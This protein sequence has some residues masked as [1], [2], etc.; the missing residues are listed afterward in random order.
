MSELLNLL[1][2]IVDETASRDQKFNSVFGTQQMSSRYIDAQ[3]NFRY[4]LASDD[5]ETPTS[6]TGTTGVTEGVGFAESNNTTGTT[7]IENRNPVR[8][9]PGSETGFI[10]TAAIP[11]TDP[12]ATCRIGGFDGNDGAFLGHDGDEY[13]LGQ[14]RD[15]V[16]TTI[17]KSKW[18]GN[19]TGLDLSGLNVYRIYFGYLGS[20]PVT[21]QVLTDD[22]GWITL[23]RFTFQGT[24]DVNFINPTLPLRMEVETTADVQARV[25]SGS[26]V[27][28]SLAEPTKDPQS[29]PFTRRNIRDAPAAD[30]DEHVIT[31]RVKETY[32]GQTNKVPV[33]P[34]RFAPFAKSTAYVEYTLAKNCS[35]GT[36]LTYT[37]VNTE[38][39]V[40]E[41]SDDAVTV[42]GTGR[43]VSRPVLDGGGGG[44]N[45]VG[46]QADKSLLSQRLKPGDT[47]TAF[48]TSSGPDTYAS[49]INWRELF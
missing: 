39:S 27:G 12:D 48:A 44:S 25:E 30:T 28:Y 8:Y 15:G 37:D 23:D 7:T 17:P 11:A 2:A 29:R 46:D 47:L 21:F 45:V 36:A 6:N 33:L 22:R 42:T 35:F 13:I 9:R 19:T 18:D 41:W 3:T 20:A 4:N 14:R 16:D 24:P 43:L 40:V 31:I 5:L 32:Q 34:V 38:N 10:F 1:G 26:W 49:S